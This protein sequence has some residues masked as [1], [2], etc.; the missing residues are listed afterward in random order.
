M[1]LFETFG[2]KVITETKKNFVIYIYCNKFAAH[3]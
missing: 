3:F 1:A 2:S